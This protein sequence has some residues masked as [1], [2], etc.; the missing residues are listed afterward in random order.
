MTV[1]QFSSQR[2]ACSHLTSVKGCKSLQK[3]AFQRN[4]EDFN[5]GFFEWGGRRGEKNQKG[6]EGKYH[7]MSSSVRTAATEDD[8]KAAAD[9]AWPNPVFK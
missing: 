1:P 5:H 2:I 4:A 9:S 6:K 7:H 3:T 8:K